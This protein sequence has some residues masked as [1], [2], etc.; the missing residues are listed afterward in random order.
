MDIGGWQTG[1]TGHSAPP[2][3]NLVHTCTAGGQTYDLRY[4]AMAPAAAMLSL[5]LPQSLASGRRAASCVDRC[6]QVWACV[7][8]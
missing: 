1:S 5:A 7:G 4:D 3:L 8:R 6:R 2:F